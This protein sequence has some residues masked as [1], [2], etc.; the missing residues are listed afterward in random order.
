M[1]IILALFLG[2]IAVFA[3][4]TEYQLVDLGP[5]DAE[6]FAG[7][8]SD[9]KLIVVRSSLP[10]PGGHCDLLYRQQDLLAATPLNCG[11]ILAATIAN[12]NNRGQVVGGMVQDGRYYPAL[13]DARLN[14]TVILGSLGGVPAAGF[15]GEAT[16]INNGGTIVGYSYRDAVTRRA[17]VWRES[18]M[19]ELASLGGYS[20]ATAIND[21]GT[22]VGFASDTFNGRAVAVVWMNGAIYN[23][24]PFAGGESYAQDVNAQ[25][26]VVGQGLKADQMAFHAFL[27]RNGKAMDLGTLPSGRNSHARAINNRSQVVGWADVVQEQIETNSSGQSFTNFVYDRRGFLYENGAMKDLNTLVE[28]SGWNLN[29][30]SDIN[31]SGEIV[32]YGE[33]GGRFRAF[34]LSPAKK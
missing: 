10:G 14:Q 23:I 15:T 7:S 13:F 1:K 16:A 24:D 33:V 25:N 11:S 20:V 30:P 29:W 5:A 32:G 3:N 18:R 9:S 28:A 22:I 8:I 12:V 17:F 26:E 31:N 6:S 4:A 27:W 21:S 2:C 34:L 19:T